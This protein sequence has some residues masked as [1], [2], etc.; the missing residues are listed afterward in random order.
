MSVW[1]SGALPLLAVGAVGLAVALP[2]ALTAERWSAGSLL[3]FVGKERG[4]SEWLAAWE[5]ETGAPERG[6]AALGINRGAGVLL[7]VRG[8]GTEWG[9][10]AGRIGQKKQGIM[11]LGP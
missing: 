8:E 10:P 9:S 11:A 5:Q 3:W 1:L 4:R 7:E 2:L 6:T